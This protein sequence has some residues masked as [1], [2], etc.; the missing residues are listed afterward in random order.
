[1]HWH[2]V[3]SNELTQLKRTRFEKIIW[4]SS[5]IKIW[6]KRAKI[7]RKKSSSYP[8]RRLFMRAT[9]PPIWQL[10]VASST[11]WSSTLHFSCASALHF[12]LSITER[13]N[14]F[15]HPIDFW[16]K[17]SYLSING[18][19][20]SRQSSPSAV[21]WWCPCPSLHEGI[22]YASVLDFIFS[23]SWRFVMW[24]CRHLVLPFLWVTNICAKPC[25][26]DSFNRSTPATRRMAAVHQEESS[27]LHWWGRTVPHQSFAHDR[28]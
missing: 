15:G 21:S 24:W 1:M 5:F 12:I 10:P 13:L 16:R 3:V 17:I 4:P 11:E 22:L 19:K 20:P 6:L 14:Q 27:L 8:C 18:E 9:P 2:E 25:L 26:S 23:S 28:C 7:W